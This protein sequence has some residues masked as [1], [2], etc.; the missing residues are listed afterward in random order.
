MAHS[1]KELFLI[2]KYH[3]LQFF[4]QFTLEIRILVNL[5]SKFTINI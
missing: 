4:M 3:F 5:Q 2:F 1:I